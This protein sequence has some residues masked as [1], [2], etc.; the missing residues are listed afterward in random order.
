MVVKTS[1]SYSGYL[2][3]IGVCYLNEYITLPLQSWSIKIIKWVNTQDYVITILSFFHLTELL[4]S[5]H[6]LQKT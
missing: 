4:V 1:Y 6:L 2:I 5:P 3:E